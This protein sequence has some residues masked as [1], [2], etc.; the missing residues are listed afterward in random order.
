MSR[1]SE[2]LKSKNRIEKMQRARRRDEIALLRKQS[3]FKAKL[4]E[5]MS[6]VGIL[7]KSCEVEC[8]VI[9]VEEEFI[10]AF[11]TAI[12]TEDLAEYNVQQID[13][14]TFGIRRKQVNF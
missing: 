7:L 10:S 9:T 4:Y 14:N 3:T 1:T 5:E 13:T 6:K 11:N 2:V 12:Y 8:I